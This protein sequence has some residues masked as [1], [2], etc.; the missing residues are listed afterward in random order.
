MWYGR[1]PFHTGHH[2]RSTSAQSRGPKPALARGLIA[3]YGLLA[4]CSSIPTQAR[5]DLIGAD[6]SAL[7]ACAGVPDNREALPDG[8][9]LEWRQD[10]QVQG[11]L[12]LKT[13]LSFELDIGGHGTCHL[14]ARL[15]QGHVVQ[16]EYTGPSATLSGPYAACRPLVLACEKW[17][18]H[19]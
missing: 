2:R 5:H 7:I 10:A 11:P 13:P 9:V 8:E 14:V 18:T 12:T 4:S 15:R 3:A 16:I 6:R 17:T 1:E 19:K